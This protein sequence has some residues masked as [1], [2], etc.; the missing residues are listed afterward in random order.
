MARYRNNGP[1][2]RKIQSPV[3]PAVPHVT[4]QD[5]GFAVDGGPVRPNR[6]HIHRGDR[7]P[8][9]SKTLATRFPKSVASTPIAR[10]HVAPEFR[11]RRKH[12]RGRIGMS[13]AL[14]GCDHLAGCCPSTGNNR[15]S[16]SVSST[17]SSNVLPAIV[18]VRKR[19]GKDRAK[20]LL[21]TS[22]SSADSATAA[23]PVDE[24]RVDSGQSIPRHGSTPMDRPASC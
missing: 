23:P 3:R 24:R 2:D 14:V 10:D 9:S 18:A 22:R 5:T 16:C 7:P 17:A 15:R 13:C 20:K 6:G 1:S 4:P 11:L 19:S 8:P 12:P 21:V